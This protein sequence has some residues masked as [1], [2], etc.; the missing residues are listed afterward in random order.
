MMLDII[1]QYKRTLMARGLSSHTIR[2]YENDLLQFET[3]LHKFF[4]D[5][6]I[7]LSEINR[8]F[9]RDYL[10]FLNENNRS[11]R[12]LAR[13]VTVI[14]NFFKFCKINNI[15]T[16]NPA[17]NLPTPKF[18]KIL[19]KYFTET[20]MNKLL[21]IP[22]IKTK[23]GVRNKA[24]MELIYSC[25]LRVS[26]VSGC[27][28]NSLDLNSRLVRVIGKG[29]KE[30]IIPIGKKA[31]KA[32]REYLKIRQKF[33][34]KEKN[35]SVFLTK[36]GNKLL[37][38]ELRQIIDRYILLIAQTKGYSPHSLRHSFATH[39]TANGADLIAVQEML[40]HANLS[41]TEIYTH[42]TL[43]D[44]RKEYEQAHPRSKKE[45]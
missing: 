3:F 4:E 37:P 36:S 32:M 20:E 44:L 31:V 18:E 43:E 14:R 27:K 24:I 33:V 21:E 38:D 30:R 10:R 28:I 7:I 41:S 5:R 9:I 17:L 15:I 11:N 34:S 39:L 45:D 42:L 19:P 23:F 16:K 22:D 8:L 25:G 26:E 13:K 12:T 40:G 29:N 2:A 35:N 1:E 6:N